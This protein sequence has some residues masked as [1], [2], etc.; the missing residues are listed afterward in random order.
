MLAGGGKAVQVETVAKMKLRAKALAA[1]ASGL[2][3]TKGAMQKA[4]YHAYVASKHTVG[5]LP[6]KSET[7]KVASNAVRVQ[8]SSSALS[9]GS[10]HAG[11]EPTQKQTVESSE[12]DVVVLPF[13]M[14]G[15][16]MFG[17]M[18]SFL[19]GRRS[20]ATKAPV[21]LES[22]R[23]VVPPKLAAVVPSD[24]LSVN[25]AADEL[26]AERERLEAERREAQARFS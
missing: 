13:A 4:L 23:T 1:E 21:S 16:M 6:F 9:V 11:K 20:S 18:A 3:G 17:A 19:L 7:P 24:E 25:Q 26:A 5:G 15:A 14:C 10:N 2:V 8:S 22:V 12:V